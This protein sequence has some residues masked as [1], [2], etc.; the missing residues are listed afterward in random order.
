MVNRFLLKDQRV[1]K[2]F[3]EASLLCENHERLYAEY[4]SLIGA[5][6]GDA[7]IDTIELA[8]SLESIVKIRDWLNDRIQKIE[9]KRIIKRRR[10]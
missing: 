1:I 2:Y 7:R 10:I 9:K 8:C 6:N 4:I 3:G 5:S